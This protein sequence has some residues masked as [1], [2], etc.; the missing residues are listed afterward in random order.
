MAQYSE[1]QN[2]GVPAL[3]EY[4]TG[5]PVH[6]TSED[7]F[8]LYNHVIKQLNSKFNKTVEGEY[9]PI[10]KNWF[11]KI[12]MIRWWTRTRADM[13]GPIGWGLSLILSFL[14]GF[15]P[16]VNLFHFLYWLMVYII[17]ERRN[18]VHR[19]NKALCKDPFENMVFA[20]K[21]CSK[22]E[23]MNAYMTLPLAQLGDL[24]LKPNQIVKLESR[25]TNDTVTFM[26]Y[27]RRF[28][29]AWSLFSWL[30]L[31]HILHVMVV[32]AAILISNLLI[33]PAIGIDEF[34]L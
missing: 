16:V 27:N 7:P 21:F 8:T 6:L 22:F 18:K 17:Y 10:E 5:K 19:R 24:E 25:A 34:I 20:P 32:I 14:I 4:N 26:L 33:Y 9:Y 15:A 11:Y 3:K 1:L 12:W 29:A 30:R 28:Y 31:F 13:T 2:T 23:V